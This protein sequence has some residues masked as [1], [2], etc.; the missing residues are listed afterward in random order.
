M[1]T[2]TENPYVWANNSIFIKSSVLS[3]NLKEEDGSRLNISGLS[4]P[5]ELVIPEKGPKEPVKNNDDEH[6]FVKPYNNPNDIR[7]HKIVIDSSLGSAT[8][9]IRPANN[10]VFDVFVSPEVKPR[11]DN[12]TFKTIIP[13]F[14]SC[15]NPNSENGY[16]NCIN[17]SYTFALPASVTERVGELFIGIRLASYVSKRN[18]RSH[19]TTSCTDRN[20]RQKRSC[21]GVKPPPTTPPRILIPKYDNETDVNYTMSVKIQNCLYW[22]DSRQ[23]WTN[24]GCTVSFL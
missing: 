15:T 11:P 9:K 24:D 22:S 14:S 18:K 7:Y 4:H 8:V 2:F 16:S 23:D 5:I 6:F 1:V 10:A 3:L 20:G 21:I 13:N 12:Y 17:D 19:I